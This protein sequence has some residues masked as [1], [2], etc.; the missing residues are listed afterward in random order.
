MVEI[1]QKMEHRSL[2]YAQ[3]DIL[4]SS[5]KCQVSIIFKNVLNVVFF[6]PI[7]IP[8]RILRNGVSFHN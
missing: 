8:E 2:A 5:A 7:Y 6:F 4:A 1:V 3:L